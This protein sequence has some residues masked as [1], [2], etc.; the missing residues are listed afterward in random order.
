LLSA[1]SETPVDAPESPVRDEGADTHPNT[2]G[3]TTARPDAPQQ[4]GR[5]S[6]RWPWQ[7]R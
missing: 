3:G 6:W 4:A 1:M 2:Q 5:P 7:R